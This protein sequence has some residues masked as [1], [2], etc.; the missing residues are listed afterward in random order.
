MGP[1]RLGT[2][3]IYVRIFRLRQT[4]YVPYP[5]RRSLSDVRRI[6]LRVEDC[7]PK[8]PYA[9]WTASRHTS[10]QG[11]SGVIRMKTNFPCVSCIF[12]AEC[13]V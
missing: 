5:H 8:I 13:E 7:R 4:E 6:N 3:L 2:L 11:F 9:A 10:L 1:T 12:A